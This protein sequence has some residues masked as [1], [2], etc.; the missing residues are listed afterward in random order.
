MVIAP[1]DTPPP[2][3]VPAAAAPR[4]VRVH[5]FDF[6]RMHG[7]IAASGRLDCAGC[8]QQPLH[9]L[10]PGR[11]RAPLPPVQFRGAARQRVVCAGDEC[12]SCHNTEVFCRSCHRDVAESA[13]HRSAARVRRTPASPC[14]Y[15]NTARRRVGACR[16]AHHAI[17][18]RTASSA[19]PRSGAGSIRTAQTSTPTRCGSGTRRS[20]PTAT[21][22]S[23]A[24]AGQRTVAPSSPL[25][26]TV[27]HRK[28]TGIPRITIARPRNAS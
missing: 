21:S 4:V 28:Y 27:R 11:R 26:S 10:P 19:T 6:V 25:P 17:N 22:V 8:H 2:P 20:A 3:L 23:L 1:V 12:T 5:A 9:E 24:D 14:G 13:R 7:P 16:A 18:R 15:C